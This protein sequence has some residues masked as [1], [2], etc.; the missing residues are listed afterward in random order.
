MPTLKPVGHQST[1]W[2]VRLAFM[3]AMAAFTSLGTTSPRYNKPCVEKIE[4]RYD[5]WNELC[6]DSKWI[7]A[8]QIGST[9]WKE[10]INRLKL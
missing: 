8:K 3:E 5:M 2:T 7:K 9:V 4:I 6:L 1:N 10:S